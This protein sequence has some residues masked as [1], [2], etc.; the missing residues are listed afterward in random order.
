MRQKK[1]L[2]VIG[3]ACLIGFLALH[4]A[5]MALAAWTKVNGVYTDSA[6]TSIAGVTARGI[7]ISHWQKDIDWNAVAA[8]DIQFVMLGTRYNNAEDPSFRSNAVAASKAGLKVGAYIYSYATTVEMAKQEADF[9][10]NL[11]KDYPISYPVVLDVEAS[12]LSA[13]SPSKLSAIINTFCKTVKDAGYYP[14]VYANDY[15]LTNKID[16]KSVDYDVWVA[17]YDVRHSYS[18]AS[19]WQAT[20]RGTVAGIS[21]NVDINFSYK[22]FSALIPSNQWRNI[23]GKWYYYKN[24]QMTKGWSHD[25]NGWY[26]MGTDGSPAKGWLKLND[27]YFHLDETTGKMTV[28]WF[29]DPST[30]KWYYLAQDG[31]LAY[32]WQQIDG[33]RYYLGT[34]GTMATG[35]KQIDGEWHYFGRDGKMATG[36]RM[37]DGRYYYLDSDG[38]MKT[39]WQQIEGGWYFLSPEGKLR[40]GWQQIDGS[41]YY[42]GED[43][44]MTT[45]WQK[46]K[47]LWYY[48]DTDGKMLTGWQKIGGESYYLHTD[49]RMLTGWLN[50]NAG[51][52]YYMSPSSGRMIRG[53]RQIENSWYYFDNTG[54]MIKGWLKLN[55]SYYYLDP[56]TG[57]MVSNASKVI[58][59]VTY[60]F[61]KSGVCQNET[62]SMSGIT[63]ADPGGLSGSTGTEGNREPGG[64]NSFN[65]SENPDYPGSSSSPSGNPEYPGGS[66]GSSGNPSYPGGS[67]SP[68]GNPGYPGS[69]SG[70]SSEPSYPGS[71]SSPSGNSGSSFELQPGLTT[72]PGK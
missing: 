44:K 65:S 55:S 49:G 63:A 43:G 13:L 47:G 32:G 20:N 37:I 10:L 28:G 40:V 45:G 59:R 68:S 41:W 3:A 62:N 39:G 30:S 12:E 64:G 54:H 72:G 1:R 58:D 23:G 42:L 48:L 57:V 7:D 52:R 2:Q 19:M 5:S 18:D 61:D 11:I 66:S 35:W 56:S 17:R 33:K 29:Q 38:C 36:W 53:W 22:D 69:S 70:S 31:T 34:D 24:Y 16:M 25:G 50:D 6:G 14:M 21:G 4:S 51:N 71:S 27:K 67:S 46:I 60:T 8:D 9:V 15:W 26:Y